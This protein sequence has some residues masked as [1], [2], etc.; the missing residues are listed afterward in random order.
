LRYDAPLHA[1][2]HDAL[3]KTFFDI[4]MAGRAQAA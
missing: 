1:D 4:A 2:Q 3:E